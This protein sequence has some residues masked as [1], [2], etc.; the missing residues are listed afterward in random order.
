VIASTEAILKEACGNRLKTHWDATIGREYTINADGTITKRDIEGS[1][2]TAGITY[3]WRT[4]SYIP[5]KKVKKTKT[6]VVKQTKYGK[7][8]PPYWVIKKAKEELEYG[9]GF[10]SRAGYDG[11]DAQKHQGIRPNGEKYN[12][13]QYCNP[14]AFEDDL[15]E[16]LR[17]DYFNQSADDW[18]SQYYNWS[19][20]N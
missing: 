7:G 17:G 6:K 19:Y 1:E 11:Y 15:V 2:A 14:C 13:P 5:K 3:D 12:L 9:V 10:D 4:Y 18:D 20:Y 16:I 8:R